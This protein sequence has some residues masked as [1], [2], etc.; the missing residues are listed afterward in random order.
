MMVKI[1]FDADLGEFAA[2]AADGSWMEV[3]VTR[4]VHIMETEAIRDRH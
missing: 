1:P 3:H 4:A 2:R